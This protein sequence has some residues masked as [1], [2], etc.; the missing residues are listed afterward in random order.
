MGDVGGAEGADVHFLNGVW[1]GRRGG[2]GKR[3]GGGGKG[4]FLGGMKGTDGG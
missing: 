2:G 3:W 4:G 1:V